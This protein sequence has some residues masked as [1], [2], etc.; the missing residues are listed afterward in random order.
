MIISKMNVLKPL[1]DSKEGQHLTVYVENDG[2]IFYIREQLREALDKAYH[3][4]APVMHPDALIRFLAPLHNLVAED[5]R[6][7]HGFKGNIGIFRNEQSF[8]LLSVPVAIEKTFVVAKS[9]HV[10]PLLRWMQ[11]DRDFLLLRLGDNGAVFLQGNQTSISLLDTI[12]FSDMK[13]SSAGK[14]GIKKLRTQRRKS[15]Y[16][17]MCIEHLNENMKKYLADDNL[18]VFVSGPKEWTESF[19]KK[20]PATKVYV[21]TP[22]QTE[23]VDEQADLAAQARVIMKLDARRDFEQSLLEFYRADHLNFANK[24]IFVIAKAA[25][26]GKVKKLIVANEINIFGKIDKSSG[27]VSV[28]GEHLDHEDDD[29]LDDLAQEVLFHGGEVVVASQDDI[30]MRRPILA[31]LDAPEPTLPKQKSINE[32]EVR[33]MSGAL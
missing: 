18:R 1:L 27:R 5:S 14:E 21:L 28:H 26:N 29:L 2:N 33:E 24:S 4:L 7:L 31:I 13:L 32:Q 16:I 15:S 10:K 20:F 8:R 6:L 25:I 12:V 11:F 22:T 3:Y 19:V 17:K 9:F 23:G 30:P